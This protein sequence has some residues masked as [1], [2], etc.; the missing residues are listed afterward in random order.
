M[1]SSVELNELMERI[2]QA[3]NQENGLAGSALKEVSATTD[4]P[5]VPEMLP[6]PPSSEQGSTRVAET[7]R[8]EIL[9]DHAAS[10][11]LG[12]R[13]KNAVPAG[14]P[15][16]LRRFFRNQGGVNGVVMEA[17]DSLIEVNR[18]LRQ[19]NYELH[20]RLMD[21]HTWAHAV[22]EASAENRNWMLVADARLRATSEEARYAQIE[23]RLARL[24]RRREPEDG[25]GSAPLVSPDPVAAS[26]TPL[27]QIA[28]RL[29]ALEA[30]RTRLREHLSLLEAQAREH[31]A[32]ARTVHGHLDRL[33]AHVESGFA[34]L[35][36]ER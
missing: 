31:A 32:Y 26:E 13:A 28:A 16:I 25:D 36:P 30:E 19:Q 15:K 10:M 2:R 35:T 8:P 33:G 23:E 34:R 27:A 29:E 12:G 21:F 5:P 3:A 1:K 9:L 11:L 20:E 7:T 14:V 24:E 17:L 4:L 6:L 22:A 18:T